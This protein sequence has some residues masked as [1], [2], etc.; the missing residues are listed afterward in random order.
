MTKTMRSAWSLHGISVEM[1][2]ADPD[3]AAA[4]ARLMEV[5]PRAEPTRAEVRFDLL[6][7]DAAQ[8]ASRQL[9]RDR[10]DHWPGLEVGA[11]G[12][13]LWFR[14]ER[15]GS[16]VMVDLRAH[17]GWAY[18]ADGQITPQAME[19]IFTGLIPMALAQILTRRG[20]FSIHACGAAR[21][22]RAVVAAGGRGAGKSTLAMSLARAGLG[23]L[24]DDRVLVRHAAADIECLSWPG[25]V[26]LT[27]RSIGLFAE[28]AG[29]PLVASPLQGKWAVPAEA[30]CRSPA[31]DSARARLLL[32]P[33]VSD[34]AES[35]FEPLRAGEALVQLVPCS[36]F[37]VHRQVLAEHLATLRDLVAA[38]RC[39]RVQLGR[40]VAQVGERVADLLLST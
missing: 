23:V 37:Y 22:G 34:R 28:L 4:A 2:S 30:V 19:V 16:L 20:I 32:F 13:L 29:A 6:R 31:V 7:A 35:A 25:P 1:V 24:S 15:C 26:N 11:D 38:C 17:R 14:R 33:T 39:Y 9:P 12:H 27:E 5:W 10:C 3:M 40:D 8:L 18:L 36:L 21:D